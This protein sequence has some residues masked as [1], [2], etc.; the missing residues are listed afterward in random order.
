MSL[1]RH[2]Q[3]QEQ[4]REKMIDEKKREGSFLLNEN[5]FYYVLNHTKDMYVHV[6]TVVSDMMMMMKR[7]KLCFGILKKYYKT[8]E[9]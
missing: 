4:N 7:L 9:K 5:L 2:E 8:C 1:N 6:S 3:E